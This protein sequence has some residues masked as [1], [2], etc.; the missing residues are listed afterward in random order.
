ML[1]GHIAKLCYHRS[2][3][4]ID[5]FKRCVFLS[6]EEDTVDV[7]TLVN[8]IHCTIPAWGLLGQLLRSWKGGIMQVDAKC[9]YAQCF[10]S[11]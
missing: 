5:G 4:R 2:L 11:L 8:Y 7:Q 10:V 9:C 6:G 3:G 1:A